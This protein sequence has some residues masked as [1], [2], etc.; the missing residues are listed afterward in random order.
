MEITYRRIKERFIRIYV[1]VTF[2]VSMKKK[3]MTNVWIIKEDGLKKII[4]EGIGHI[5]YSFKKNCIEKYKNGNRFKYQAL[6]G[7]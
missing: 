3:V 2:Q 7:S 5:G 6:K 1:L 4:G